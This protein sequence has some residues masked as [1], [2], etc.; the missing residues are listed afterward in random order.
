[1]LLRIKE[2]KRDLCNESISR[3]D[4]LNRFNKVS[5]KIL[6]DDNTVKRTIYKISL[7]DKLNNQF[8]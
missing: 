2:Y 3:N 5:S 7:S 1:M 6:E 8:Y 4:L